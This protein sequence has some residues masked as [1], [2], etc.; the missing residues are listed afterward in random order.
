MSNKKL[1]AEENRKIKDIDACQCEQAG[2]CPLM[3][4]T[5]GFTLHQKCQNDKRF[6]EEYYGIRQQVESDPKI[7]AAR[8][9][10]RERRDQEDK[11]DRAIEHL[12]S[13][14]L[15]LKKIEEIMGIESASRGLGDTIEKTLSKFGI[16]SKLIEKIMGTKGCG[17]NERK[18]W[19]NKIFPYKK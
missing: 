13:Q 12:K 11:L 8:K 15:S 3:G 14:G 18:D 17:C 2:W 1:C 6:R 19:L 10:S 16:T 5:M 7:L 4:K 9:A